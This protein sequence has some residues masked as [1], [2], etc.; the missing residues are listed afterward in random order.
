M[1][2][3]IERISHDADPERCQA[4]IP[5]SGQ[6]RNKAIPGQK[7]CAA[8]G[9]ATHRNKAE[10]EARSRNYCLTQAGIK[11]SVAEKAQSSGIKSLR[12]EIAIARVTLEAVLNKC[13]DAGDLLIFH[14]QIDRSV[15]TIEKLVTS[16]HKIEKSM[17]LLLDKQ[18]ILV[19]IGQVVEAITSIIQEQDPVILPETVQLDLINQISTKLFDIVK[20]VGE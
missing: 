20:T 8:H 16:C 12:D 15:A 1:S 11:K 19:I 4:V 2:D 17:A 10:S 7:Y 3:Q 5:S 18:A 13:E 9:G 14:S 6:C